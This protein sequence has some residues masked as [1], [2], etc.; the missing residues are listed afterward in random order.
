[1][2]LAGML[3]PV[4][5][6]DPKDDTVSSAIFA[7]SHWR[8][9]V[10]WRTNVFLGQVHYLVDGGYVNNLPADVVKD[11]FGA[12]TVIAVDIGADT[13]MTGAVDYGESLPGLKLLWHAINPWAKPIKVGIICMYYMYVCIVCI[14]CIIFIVCM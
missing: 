4:C 2:S 9:L 1:M 5:D 14:T 7:Y 11:R 6:V 8:L 10:D 13:C 3:P 12:S